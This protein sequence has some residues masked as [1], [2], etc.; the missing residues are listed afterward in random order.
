MKVSLKNI[1]NPYSIFALSWTICLI[2]Y[3][4]GWAEIFPPISFNLGMYL[5]FL[6]VVFIISSTFY[7]KLPLITKGPKFSLKY[8]SL[9]IINALI[10]SSNF[11]YSGIPLLKGIRENEFGIPTVI[12]LATTLN[13]FTSVYCF[14]IFLNTK[15]KIFLL[16]SGL[17]LCFFVL[18]FSRGNIVMS[19][20]TMFFL[21]MNVSS[22]K[23][24]VKNLIGIISGFLLVAYLFGVAGNYRTINDL[25]NQGITSDDSYNSNVIMGLG[26]ASESFKESII[27][28]EF[29]WTYLYITSPLSNL[30][31]N[32]NKNK[33][34]LSFNG[35][36]NLFIDEILFDT[37]SKRIDNLL[38]RKRAEPDLI[39]EQLTVPTTLAGSY[40]YAGWWGMTIFIT[41]FW[42]FPFIYTFFIM[43]NPLGVI[44]VSTLC[45][46]YFLSIFDNMF[47]LT[48]LM[49]QIFFPVI[50]FFVSKVKVVKTNNI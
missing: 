45:T 31:Y 22:P 14:Y 8:K 35:I 17:C 5:I 38:N 11:L 42:I 16:Y 28:G 3:S 40:N 41:V 26:G 46:V 39:I 33:T 6:I 24:T 48:S 34:S 43:K 23:L 15:R 36:K 20:M 27:P 19:V 10:Y 7:N 1:S 37:V 18:V 30:Q 50:L 2:L 47:I 44:G 49:L 4:F 12:V 9:L 25:N 21:W 13:C 29:F 32:V